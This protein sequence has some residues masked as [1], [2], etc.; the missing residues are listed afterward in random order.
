MLPLRTEQRF[1]WELAKTTAVLIILYMRSNISGWEKA[2]FWCAPN[3]LICYAVRIG[4]YKPSALPFCQLFSWISNSH[5][6]QTEEETP[7]LAH[8]SRTVKHG[9]PRAFEKDIFHV[10]IIQVATDAPSAPNLGCYSQQILKESKLQ[11]GAAQA[12]AGERNSSVKLEMQ[13]Q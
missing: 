9:A 13:C 8:C 5:I 11:K 7:G 6:T 10:S 2:G 4:K 12:D 1:F 3:P